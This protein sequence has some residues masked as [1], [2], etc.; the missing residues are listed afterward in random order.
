M[1]AK[2]QGYDS[3]DMPMG[4]PGFPNGGRGDTNHIEEEEA[5]YFFSQFLPKA[6]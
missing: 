1:I 2:R 4:D 3:C 6:A 5:T